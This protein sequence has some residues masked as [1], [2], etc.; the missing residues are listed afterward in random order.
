MKTVEAMLTIDVYLSCPF[1]K[2]HI[3]LLQSEH[4]NGYDHN[5]DGDVLSQACPA[6]DRHWSE[7]HKTFEVTDVTCSECKKTFDIKGLEW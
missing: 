2:C 6:G 3:S 4:T 1:C 5:E 7:E